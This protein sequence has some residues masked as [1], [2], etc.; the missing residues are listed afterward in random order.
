MKIWTNGCF[1]ILHIG[2]I[3]M[4]EFARSLGGSL[5]VGIDSD[6]RV[7][8]LKGKGRP[9]NNQESRKKILESLRFIDKV[10]IFDTK[11]EMEKIL[12]ENNLDLIVVGDEYKDGQVTGSEICPVRFFEKIPGISTTKILER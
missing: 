4:L 10:F 6:E 9:I 7:R 3:Q 2:H 8:S 5:Y 12:I 1:D 11:E